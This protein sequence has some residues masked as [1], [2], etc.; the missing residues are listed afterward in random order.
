MGMNRTIGREEEGRRMPKGK[1]L[2]VLAVGVFFSVAALAGD[3]VHI[4]W[5]VTA[6]QNERV[7]RPMA[8]RLYDEACRWVEDRFGHVGRM[9]RPRLTI[10]V[11]EVCPDSEI[12]S[13]CLSP[14]SGVLYIPEWNEAAPGAIV[15]ATIVVGMLQLLEREDLRDVVKS[16]VAEE[17]RNFVDAKALSRR[18]EDE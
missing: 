5:V 18:S 3:R 11:G 7:D 12:R 6:D 13:A 16:L 1:L 10:H 2:S 14:A 4:R 17:S 15:H 8:E 9:I